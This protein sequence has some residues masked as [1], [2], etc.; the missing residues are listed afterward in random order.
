M[1][2]SSLEVVFRVRVMCRARCAHEV[3]R[4]Q[5][6]GRGLRRMCV[7]F[8]RP[9]FV[10]PVVSRLVSQLDPLVSRP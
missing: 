5:W 8:L 4:I 10:V 7:L 9:R 6:A 1:V 2:P 3:A